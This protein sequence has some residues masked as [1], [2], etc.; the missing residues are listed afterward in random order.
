LEQESRLEPITTCQYDTVK[1]VFLLHRRP[2]KVSKC[3]FMRSLR[4]VQLKRV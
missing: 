3:V 2:R 4:A 1:S